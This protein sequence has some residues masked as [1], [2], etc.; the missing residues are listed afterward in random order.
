MTMNLKYKYFLLLLVPYFGVAQSADNSIFSRFGLGDFTNNQRVSSIG[1]GSLKNS[2][3]DVFNTNFD[4]PATLVSLKA[5]T[6]EG[7]IYAKYAQLTKDNNKASVWSGNLSYLSIAFPLKNP[8]EEALQKAPDKYH[9]AIGL[10]LAPYTNV[11]YNIVEDRAHP[12]IDT[13]TNT[14]NGSGAIYKMQLGSAIS[15]KNFSFG[16]NIGWLFGKITNYRQLDFQNIDLAY[17][18]YFNDA[19][20]VNGFNWHAGL[21]YTFDMSKSE[22]KKEIIHPG[23]VLTLGLTGHSAQSFTTNKS[24]LYRRINAPFAGSGSPIDTFL[25]GNS[26]LEG[27]KGK[28][29]LPAELGFGVQYSHSTKM[30]MGIDL[31]YAD[32]SDYRNDAKPDSTIVKF[33]SA[34]HIGAGVEICPNPDDYKY[35]YRKIRYRFGVYYDQDPREINGVSLTNYGIS[36]G[37]GLPI[38]LPRQQTS[39]LQWAIEAGQFKGSDNIKETYV[40]LHFGFTFNDSSWF[41]K[42]RFD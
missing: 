5:A 3:N 20:S 21:L 31:T 2:Y 26:P 39:F 14:F 41:Y 17:S 10:N 34:F 36:L 23:R 9:Y 24:Y 25:I 13:T 16:L 12:G 35:Y 1:M 11:N 32:W 38:K 40:R 30:K 22:N 19:F 29:K 8:V 37:M 6:Y 28:G 4:N 18:D 42:R 27:V 15:Y 33:K 7:G